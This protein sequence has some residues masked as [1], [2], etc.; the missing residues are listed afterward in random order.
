[1]NPEDCWCGHHRDR[2][3]PPDDPAWFAMLVVAMVV[4]A[5]FGAGWFVDWLHS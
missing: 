4:L 3:E 5:I 2:N 1:M